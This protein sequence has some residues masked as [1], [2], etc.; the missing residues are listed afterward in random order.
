VIVVVDICWPLMALLWV[1][2][3]AYLFIRSRQVRGDWGLDPSEPVGFGL[4]CIIL[5]L[6]LYIVHLK[7][8]S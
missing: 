2:Y 8:C 3:A 4:A 1:C 6:C 7:V 5:T